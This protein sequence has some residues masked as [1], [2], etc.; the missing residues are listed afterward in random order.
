MKSLRR[1]VALQLLVFALASPSFAGIVIV[2]KDGNP[3][4]AAATN[5]EKPQTSILGTIIT[6]LKGV[7]VSIL[8]TVVAD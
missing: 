5:S 1:L 4:P 7:I 8:G 6:D 3:P 2:G